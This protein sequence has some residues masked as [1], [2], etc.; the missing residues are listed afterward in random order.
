MAR[1][2]GENSSVGRVTA[3]D[4]ARAAGV[5]RSLVS[6]VYTEG[7][8][9]SAK[10]RKLVLKTAKKL[11]YE[12]HIA[13]RILAGK[14]SNVVGVLVGPILNPFIAALLDRLTDQ[15]RE[16]GYL[17]MLFKI[18]TDGNLMSILPSISQYSML[19]TIIVGV[20]PAVQISQQF[21]Q[22]AQSLIVL[23]LGVVR[24]VN[25]KVITTDHVGGGMLAAQALLR[26]GAKRPAVVTLDP[27]RTIYRERAAGFWQACDEVDVPHVSC[28]MSDGSYCDG[29]KATLDLMSAPDRPDA[30]FYGNDMMALGGLD[31]LR[32]KLGARV[33]DEVAVIGY[34]DSQSA[35]LGSYRLSTIRQPVDVLVTRAVEAVQKYDEGDEPHATM[36]LPPTFIPRDTTRAEVDRHGGHPAEPTLENPCHD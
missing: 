22:S 17:P 31:A 12:P 36:I 3:E 10:N 20:A 1:R 11:G 23:N 18:G 34:D 5:S 14:P 8:S 30:I 16:S 15:L 24:D 7:A 6:R 26:G 25:A 35:S 9:V 32:L 2:L 28:E 19:S 29:V 4:V 13:A 27:R 21:A 33:P